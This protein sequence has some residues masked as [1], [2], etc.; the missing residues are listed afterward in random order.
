MAVIDDTFKI[1]RKD[2]NSFTSVNEHGG[3]VFIATRS[4][5]HAESG[6]IPVDNLEQIYV[7]IKYKALISSLAV[8][9]LLQVHQLSSSNHLLIHS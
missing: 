8:S 9:T 2:R 1:F 5:I 4:S 6:T 3:G 7:K